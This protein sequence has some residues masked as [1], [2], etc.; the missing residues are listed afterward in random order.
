VAT[1]H[2]R[3]SGSQPMPPPTTN[4][5]SSRF[6]VGGSSG[7]DE[8]HQRRVVENRGRRDEAAAGDPGRGMA[9]PQQPGTEERERPDKQRVEPKERAQSSGTERFRPA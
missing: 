1:K 3:E 4:A 5:T 9:G 6:S 2:E 8:R 7:A